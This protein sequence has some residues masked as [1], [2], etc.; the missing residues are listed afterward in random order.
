M[1][2]KTI[3][4]LG[5]LL[6][7]GCQQD[8]PAAE[9]A[10]PAPA[11]AAQ[12]VAPAEKPAPAAEATAVVSDPT[13]EL[14]IDPAGTYASGKLARVDVALEARGDYH[15]NQEY[16]MTIELT[17]GEAVAIPKPKLARG[18]ATKFG[19]D[20]A[21]FEVPLTP[22]AQ[23]EHRVEAKVRFAVCTPETCVPDQRTLALALRVE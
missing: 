10:A 16:P 17:G 6:A 5:V 7:G 1:R 8:A 11:P 9:P 14:R 21:L 22:N 15:I 4:T 2:A 3:M 12:P 13:F 23:G 19:E 18:D 20:K